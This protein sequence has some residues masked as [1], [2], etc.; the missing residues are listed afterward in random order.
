MYGGYHYHGT[1]PYEPILSEGGDRNIAPRGNCRRAS[2]DPP[3]EGRRGGPLDQWRARELG[4]W[5]TLN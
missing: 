3:G 1:G 4:P 2:G 5:N